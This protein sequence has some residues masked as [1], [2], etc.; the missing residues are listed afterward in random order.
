MTM[1]AQNASWHLKIG[2]ALAAAGTAFV[3]WNT[4]TGPSGSASLPNRLGFSTTTTQPQQLN[5]VWNWGNLASASS[6]TGSGG[7]TSTGMFHVESL[8][9]IIGKLQVKDNQVI[10]NPLAGQLLES[11]FKKL[12]PHFTAEQLDELQLLLQATLPEGI[13]SQ[14]SD[15][16]GNYFHYKK[17]Y[18]QLSNDTG[19]TFDPT[20]TRDQFEEITALQQEYLGA[21]VASGLFGR[22]H[23][24]TRFAI[25]QS[26]VLRDSGLSANDKSEQ[27]A[28]LRTD[29]EDGF[30]FFDSRD[31]REI[32]D[33]QSQLT[34]ISQSTN[35]ELHGFIKKQTLQLVAAKQSTQNSVERRRWNQR[36][37]EF[38]DERQL[39][40]SA[41]LSDSDKQAQLEQ[42]SQSYFTE[43]ELSAINSF[44]PPE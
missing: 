13:G 6:Q 33:M 19:A 35:P 2:V 41:G 25:E 44:I 29:L 3:I 43:S 12:G 1:I 5:D 10:I 34:Y 26:S 28:Q 38:N 21:D 20:G 24:F 4:Q 22:Q 31:M 42:L 16:V 18:Q 9:H 15:I 23:A 37:H 17:A 30:L 11:S 8:R 32:D 14:I 39:V 40:L 7:I 27:L 36:Y